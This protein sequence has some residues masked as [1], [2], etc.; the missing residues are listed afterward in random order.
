MPIPLTRTPGQVYVDNTPPQKGHI[1]QLLA[2]IVAGVNLNNTAT[3]RIYASRAAAV[4][5]AAG[6]DALVSSVIT[7]EGQSLVFRGRGA[8]ADDPLFA[9]G[10]RWGATL[11]ID[12]AAMDGRA[13]PSYATRAAAESAAASLPAAVTQILVREGTALVIRSRTATADD[14]LYPTG[15]RWGVVQRQDTDRA[16]HTGMLPISAVEGLEDALATPDLATFPASILDEPGVIAFDPV[17]SLAVFADGAEFDFAPMLRG[18]L[19]L[20]SATAPRKAIAGRVNGRPVVAAPMN[21]ADTRAVIVPE[22]TLSSQRLIPASGDWTLV[23]AHQTLENPTTVQEVFL[24]GRNEATAIAILANGQTATGAV[25][26]V[27]DQYFLRFRGSTD[28][29]G[30]GGYPAPAPARSGSPH[31][32]AIVRRSG[33][34]A[35]EWWCDGRIVDRFTA[36]DA[37]PP[38][39]FYLFSHPDGKIISS[40]G[41]PDGQQVGRFAMCPRALNQGET[42]FVSEWVGAG[43]GIG[44]S[45]GGSGG[46]GVEFVTLTAA[47]YAALPEPQK[48]DPSKIYL[49]TA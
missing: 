36:P 46:G 25:P 2:D 39:P 6:L 18:P 12:L 42:R 26:L 14:P 20:A 37:G 49:V 1:T 11:R 15:S 31:V 44:A 35:S 43:S 21:D 33:F 24:H 22:T 13:T 45:L 9:S 17:S 29:A 7:I 5:G 34:Q 38:S 8:A 27:P 23:M 3:A 16:N 28:G 47:E 30:F 4:S 19:R 41:N 32:L 10:D 40:I 48:N